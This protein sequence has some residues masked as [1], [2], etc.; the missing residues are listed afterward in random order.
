MPAVPLLAVFAALAVE[1]LLRASAARDFARMAM[2]VAGLVVAGVFTNHEYCEASHDGMPSICLGGD[3]W[4]DQEWLKV[5]EWYRNRGVLEPALAYAERARECTSPR[6][7]G[8][9]VFWLGEIE[10]MLT[11]QSLRDGGRDAAA[12]HARRGLDF[13]QSAQ[14]LGFRRHQSLANAG[15]IHSMMGELPEAVAALESVQAAGRLDRRGMQRLGV[16][17]AGIG[18]CA[19][20]ERVLVRLDGGSPSE[21]TRTVL[22]GCTP[23]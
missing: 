17:Y 12:A 22:A 1:R 20:A 4:Y 9:I 16:A 23:R 2:L 7:A 11:Q 5:S 3:T 13:F 19:D 10:M 14:K 21:N 18:R 6:S 8:M 15:E